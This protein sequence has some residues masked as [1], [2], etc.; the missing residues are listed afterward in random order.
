MELLTAGIG[1]SIAKRLAGQGLNVVLV[2][3][4]DEL[5]SQTA[6]ELTEL[7]P[8]VLFRKVGIYEQ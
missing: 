8:S 1:K 4:G 7:Y 3:L 6:C 2:A 5:L